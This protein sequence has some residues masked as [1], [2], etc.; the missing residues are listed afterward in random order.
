M[1]CTFG[2]RSAD[3]AEGEKRI[4][5]PLKGTRDS[6]RCSAF[7]IEKQNTDTSATRTPLQ[8]RGTAPGQTMPCKTISIR[9][10]SV[11][12]RQRGEHVLRVWQKQKK[13]TQIDQMHLLR[14]LIYRRRSLRSVCDAICPNS[15]SLPGRGSPI[16]SSEGFCGESVC[17]YFCGNSF[18]NIVYRIESP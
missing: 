11:N 17:N 8:R 14:V 9:H 15:E 2:V 3:C 18:H 7:K 16:P 1:K 5:L 12:S 10:L 13:T 4:V 6:F